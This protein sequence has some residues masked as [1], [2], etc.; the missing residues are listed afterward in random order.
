MRRLQQ[1]EGFASSGDWSRRRFVQGLAAGTAAAALGLARSARALPVRPRVAELAS[2]EFDLT[3][4]PAPVNFTGAAR[5]ATAVNGNV[6]APVLRCRQGDT[7]TLRVRNALASTMSIHW[8]G[9]VL[10]ADMDGV[11]GL[12]FMGIVPGSTY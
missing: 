2:S 4:G 8:H 9:I 10:P 12:S 1:I 7:L 5:I 11:P 3:V 6:P